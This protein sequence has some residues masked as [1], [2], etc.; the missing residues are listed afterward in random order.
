M[1]NLAAFLFVAGILLIC[2]KENGVFR[3]YFYIAT[4]HNEL[5][6]VLGMLFFE[7]PELRIDWDESCRSVV[8]EWKGFVTGKAFRE[9]V[10]KGLELLVQKRGCKWLA[11]LSNMGVMSQ[12]DQNWADIDWFPRAV[13]S[14]VKYMA[15]VRPQ[16]VIPQMSVRNVLERVEDLEIET[17]Y[18]T[19]KEDAIAWLCS[20]PDR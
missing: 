3:R 9:F 16:K 7:S 6:E 18:F 13:K 12:D 17:Q 2:A 5:L 11:D 20:H 10:D 14:G 1:G 8:M 19:K 15:M 4:R